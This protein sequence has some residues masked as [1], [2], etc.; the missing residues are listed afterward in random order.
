MKIGGCD[1]ENAEV[2]G[3]ENFAGDTSYEY[4]LKLGGDYWE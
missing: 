4:G 2:G 3:A 1:C